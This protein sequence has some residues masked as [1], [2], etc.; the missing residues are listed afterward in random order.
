MTEKNEKI[1]SL[2]SNIEIEQRI[3]E[4]MIINKM[5]EPEKN[6]QKWWNPYFSV[7]MK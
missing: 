3:Q 7:A 1:N 2:N 5:K 6:K 4:K